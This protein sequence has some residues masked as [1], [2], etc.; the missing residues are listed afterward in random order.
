[1]KKRAI[2]FRLLV[3]ISMFGQ[4]TAGVCRADYITNV[5]GTTGPGEFALLSLDGTGTNGLNLT[6]PRSA[7]QIR[8][9]G[10][11]VREAMVTARIGI[12][13]SN[14]AL[15]WPLRYVIPGHP[16]VSG[17]KTLSGERIFLA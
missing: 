13:P 5:L 17:P 7:F 11:Q 3:G 1:M 15:G 2:R 9:D 8:D 16:C 6:S 12:N 10:F 4:I 14:P